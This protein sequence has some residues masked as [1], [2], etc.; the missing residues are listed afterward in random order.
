LTGA[1][2]ILATLIATA[3]L[4][5]SPCMAA[6]IV[7]HCSY[8]EL[9]TGTNGSQQYRSGDQFIRLGDDVYRTWSAADAV[10]SENQC[11]LGACHFDD[12]TFSYA[13]DTH[14]EEFGYVSRYV[15]TVAYD[16]S[17]GRYSAE[18]KTST[19]APVTNFEVETTFFE[20]GQCRAAP[21]PGLPNKS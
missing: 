14:T 5:S 3:T 20:Y 17:S 10:W 1:S 13:S 18:F 11:R 2:T 21:D 4:V 19:S 12:K 16:R 15:E 7:L 9:I 6:E 8:E